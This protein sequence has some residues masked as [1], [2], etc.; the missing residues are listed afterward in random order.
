MIRT[1]FVDTSVRARD[2]IAAPDT[3]ARWDTPSALEHMTVGALAGHL[4]RAILLPH[5]Y[6]AHADPPAADLLTAAEYFE[7][8]GLTTD[9]TDA[10]NTEIRD[11][12]A[13][14][15]AAGPA[16]L[17]DRVDRA[18]AGYRTSLAAEQPGRRVASLGGR[19]ILLD[20]YLVTRLVELAVH[21]D[22]LAVSI[23]AP[24]PELSPTAYACAIGCMLQIARDR[25]GD[26]A[27]VRA[28][29]RRERDTVSALRVL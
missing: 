15:S 21:I 8:A 20:E 9:V 3:A 25:H 19:A 29:A 18:I 7:A 27:V 4:S 22:D 23:G 14:E 26:S 11:R 24:T 17:L 13:A 12:G 2:L 1:A 28:L 6:L 16:A 5:D 10:L